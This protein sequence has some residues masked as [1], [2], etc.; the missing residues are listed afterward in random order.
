M[1]G[2]TSFVVFAA[3]VVMLAG[4]SVALARDWTDERDYGLNEH[5]TNLDQ[6]YNRTHP[7]I[8]PGTPARDGSS[9]GYV[10]P[11]GPQISSEGKC[12]VNTS[13]GNYGWTDCR[14]H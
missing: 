10:P 1:Y 13:N 8:T 4:A 12:F 5:Q 3:A 7:T 11:R 14:R 6:E 2:K 9:Y